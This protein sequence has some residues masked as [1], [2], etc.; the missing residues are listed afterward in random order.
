MS[1]NNKLVLFYNDE[2]D[3]VERDLSK[4]PDDITNFG[5]SVLAMAVIDQK[6]NLTRNIVYDHRDM[7]LTTCVRVSQRLTGDKIGL[8][9]HR[10]GG[11]F[12]SA[13]DMVGILEVN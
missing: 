2:K 3:N 7:K 11:L 8:Y 6:D 12:S 1:A 10:N 9:A 5:K 4:K 13:K